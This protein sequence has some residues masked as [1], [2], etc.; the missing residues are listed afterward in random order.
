MSHSLTPTQKAEFE[1]DGYLSAL[2]VFGLK[3]VQELRQSFE[4]FE[5]R[6]GRERSLVQR[7]DLHLLE[8]WAWQAVTDPRI[9]Q[10]VCSLLGPDVLLWSTNWFIK[11]PR[12][13]KFVSL[14]QDANYWGLL[15]HDVVTAWV[16]LSD[17]GPQTGPMQFLPGSHRGQLFDQ[18]NTYDKTNLLSRGQTIVADLDLSHAALAPLKA[19][20]MSLHHVRTIHGS[21]PNETDDR[22]IGMVLR[23]CA[24]HVRQTKAPDT[25]VLVAGS[26]TYHHFEL[27]PAPVTD[28]GEAERARHADA[29]QR[30]G[31][32]IMQ[33]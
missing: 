7:T 15:P 20:E 3:E 28:D 4:N 18:T 16:A 32:I 22:R 14:H 21:R 12:D 13:G 19:G 25:A 17:A 31:K 1:R 30:M 9:V 10:P 23:Y 5:Q 26:D 29:V 24:T 27:L 33:D 2:P 8:R 6:V 11:E